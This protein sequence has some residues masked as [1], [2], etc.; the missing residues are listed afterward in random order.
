LL[1]AGLAT[2]SLI[3]LG[4]VIGSVSGYFG[5]LIDSV[6][7]RAADVLLSIPVLVLLILVSSFFHPAWG[8]ALLIAA[9]SWPGISRWCVAK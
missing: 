5:G 6:L 2:A 1:V 7:M 8:L 9:V 3:V 4:G